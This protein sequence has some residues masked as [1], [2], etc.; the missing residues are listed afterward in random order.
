M[1]IVASEFGSVSRER[2]CRHPLD[3]V[4]Q[5]SL[6]LDGISYCGGDDIGT[7]DD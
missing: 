4:I 1:K 5:N 7:L 2:I 6:P 3:D